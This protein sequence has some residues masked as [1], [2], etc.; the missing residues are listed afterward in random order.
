MGAVLVAIGVL[1][2]NAA[3]LY[4]VLDR[5]DTGIFTVQVLL[6]LLLLAA[7][8][9]HI[10]QLDRDRRRFALSTILAD[11]AAEPSG[12]DVT[13]HGA[14]ATLLANDVADVG[15]IALADDD[16]EEEMR[17][18]ATDG[19]PPGWLDEE[20]PRALPSRTAIV[21]T[22]N[23]QDEHPW[24]AA[25]TPTIGDRP[26][27]ARIPLQSGGNPIGLLL[28]CGRGQR[29]LQDETLLE[30]LG[31]QLATALDH[32][33][34]Y[35]ASYEREQR[36]EE[37]DRRR[38][39]FIGALAHE[40]RT[41][42]TSIQAFADLLQLQP[43]AMDET[44]EQLVNSLNQGVQRLNLLVNDLLDLGQSESVGFTVAPTEVEL[45]PLF[46]QIETLLRPAYLLR[47]Q[48]LAVEIG[49]DS[50]VV[51]AD[52]QRLEQ[53]LLNLLSNAH[54]Y[55]PLGGTIS[56]RTSTNN[57]QIR[58]EIEDSGDGIPEAL[59]ERIFDPYYRVDRN[60]GTV[61][62]SGLGL[63]VA[64]Q[65]IELQSGQIWVE[66]APSGGARFCIELPRSVSAAPHETDTASGN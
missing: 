18:V 45:P 20:R 4:A 38:R 47:E 6:T 35:E 65:L 56:L 50:A 39:E 8:L 48:G 9:L 37:L 19:Y 28:L 43:M 59:R 66:A 16:S 25:V 33:A 21:T 29:A 60:D 64:R 49:A 7:A 54:R 3:V 13:A 31:S 32:A 57:G 46:A 40:V 63:A 55:T 58:I 22:G 27:V 44:A 53:V 5:I 2:V 14:L 42:L 41:P 11:L 24:V 26:W 17:P 30:R 34:M 61:H 62:G 10:R 51:Q 23:D 15:L 52:R 12:I 36:L 1:V